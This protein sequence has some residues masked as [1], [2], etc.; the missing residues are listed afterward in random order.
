MYSNTVIFIKFKI[1]SFI[2]PWWKYFNPFPLADTFWHLYSRWLFENI[3]V[4]GEIFSWLAISILATIFYI[5]FPYFCLDV[6]KVIC[7][8]FRKSLNSDSFTQPWGKCY[9]P[10]FPQTDAFWSLCPRRI[11]K[12][13]W[14]KEKLLMM[15][16]FSFCNNVF[17][18][19]QCF[20]FHL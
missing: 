10:P 17:N 11:L 15:S 2:P 8:R 9:N 16:N 20:M 7:C 19:I 1:V 4:K 13:L 3:L 14:Q 12:T 18:S 5:Y 6:F